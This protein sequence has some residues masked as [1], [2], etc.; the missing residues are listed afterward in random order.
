MNGKRRGGRLSY[1]FTDCLKSGLV[2]LG[3]EDCISLIK[4]TLSAW[5]KKNYTIALQRFPWLLQS[6]IRFENTKTF[7]TGGYA[8]KDNTD[9]KAIPVFLFFFFLMGN[10]H[11]SRLQDLEG[12]QGATGAEW[13]GLAVFFFFNTDR[14]LSKKLSLLP[15]ARCALFGVLVGSL[16]HG[17]S[18]KKRL[19]FMS[20]NQ[21]LP[22]LLCHTQIQK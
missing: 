5:G 16:Q 19:W 3:R 11:Y 12:W 8:S 4:L 17:L 1:L 15:I 22:L 10:R 20:G 14:M 21:F 13:K 18:I 9:K 2:C 7:H 6:K